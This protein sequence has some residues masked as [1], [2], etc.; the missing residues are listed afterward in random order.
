MKIGLLSDT[1]GFVDEKIYSFF[2][3]CDELWHA[4]DIGSLD[5]YDKLTHFK[6]TKAVFGNIDNH[7]IRTIIPKNQR[8]ETEGM[9]VWIT[10]I[11]GYPGRYEA[12]V[13]TE[14]LKNSPDIFVCGHSHILKIM[15]DKK[16]DFLMMN[17]GAIGNSGFHKIKT[18]LRFEIKNKDLKNLE[19]LEIER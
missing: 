11:G 13:K 1:H 19:I 18:A 12:S 10:H 2:N 6:P 5:V 15:Y 17:P 4:G 7:E 9:D 14:F 8:F 3:N 16:Y